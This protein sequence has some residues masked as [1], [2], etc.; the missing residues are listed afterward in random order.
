MPHLKQL[1][2]SRQSEYNNCGVRL[3]VHFIDMRFAENTVT[4]DP[5]D[6]IS[7]KDIIGGIMSRTFTLHGQC[8]IMLQ[9]FLQIFFQSET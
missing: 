7:I 6:R 2:Y 5:I 4:S 8:I 3:L 1:C 9:N